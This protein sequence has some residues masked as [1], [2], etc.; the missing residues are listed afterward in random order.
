MMEGFP[1]ERNPEARY[2]HPEISLMDIV[3]SNRQ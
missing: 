1:G 3:R 2:R